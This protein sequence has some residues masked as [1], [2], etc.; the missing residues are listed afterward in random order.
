MIQAGIDAREKRRVA[1]SKQQS[2]DIW[3][4]QDPVNW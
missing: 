4:P 3:N 1:K 2:I